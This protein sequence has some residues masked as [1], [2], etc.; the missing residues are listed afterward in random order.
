MKHFSFI[1]ILLFISSCATGPTY[2]QYTNTDA[3]CIKGDMANFFKFFASGEA[4][5]NILEIDGLP[6]NKGGGFSCVSPGKH[7]FGVVAN[8]NY[9]NVNDYID[10]NLESGRKYQLKANLAGISFWFK[11]HDITNNSDQ[12]VQEFKLKVNG[13]DT[14]VTVPIFIPAQ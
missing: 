14:P 10:L 4:H 13:Q 6:V 5:V 1:L 8:N 7:S 11:L 12:I 3:A 9:R 2:E